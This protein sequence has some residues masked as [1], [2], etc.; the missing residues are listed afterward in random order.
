MGRPESNASYQP[1]LGPRECDRGRSLEPRGR[2][3]A[4]G[5]EADDAG[6]REMLV[7]DGGWWEMMMDEGDAGGG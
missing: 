6:G 4:T 3:S 2:G 7:D 1:H 5:V